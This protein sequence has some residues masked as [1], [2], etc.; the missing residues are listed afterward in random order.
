[1]D[2]SSLASI[3]VACL[4]ISPGLTVDAR[5]RQSASKSTA[6]TPIRPSGGELKLYDGLTVAGGNGAAD[7]AHAPSTSE[8]LPFAPGLLSLRLQ[9]V[10]KESSRP[11]EIDNSIEGLRAYL[12][13]SYAHY[14]AIGLDVLSARFELDENQTHAIISK[15]PSSCSWSI[16]H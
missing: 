16:R 1:M 5:K 4:A 11:V 14:D 12:I 2:A 8:V 3:D 6:A 9:K 13:S 10:G 7:K 15:A